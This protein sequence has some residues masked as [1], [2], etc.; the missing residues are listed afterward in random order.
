MTINSKTKTYGDLSQRVKRAFG[1]ES[2]VQLEDEDIRTWANEGMLQLVNDNKILKSKAT[3]ITVI[4]TR[5]YDFPTQNIRQ[6]ESIHVGGRLVPNISFQE[7]ENT[8]LQIDPDFEQTGTPNYWYVWDEEFYFWPTPD[9]ELSIDLYYTR[10]PTELTGDPSQLLDVP[11]KWYSPLINYVLQ[12]AYEMDED[13]AAAQV[14][15]GQ[16]KDALMLQSEEEYLGQHLSFGVIREV[17][18]Y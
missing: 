10:Y 7:A 13:W 3:T 17:D 4:G 18:I 8:L 5:M 16:F 14:K 12:K 9:T 11:D 1:D 15:Q 2:G 6:I